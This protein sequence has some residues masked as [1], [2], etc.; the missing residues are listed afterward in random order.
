MARTLTDI[1][2]AKSGIPIKNGSSV[3]STQVTGAFKTLDTYV[4]NYP[5]IDDI[6]NKYGNIF[7][8]G[9]FVQIIGELK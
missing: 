4:K 5:T 1:M 8:N 6:D 7:Y 3:V 9:I 2:V